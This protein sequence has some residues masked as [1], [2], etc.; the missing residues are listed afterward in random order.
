MN[1]RAHRGHRHHQHVADLAGAL[2]AGEQAQHLGLTLGQA[3]LIRQSRAALIAGALV[4]AARILVGQKA[5][6]RLGVLLRVHVE[7]DEHKQDEHRRTDD[8]E[9]RGIENKVFV[10]LHSHKVAEQKADGSNEK[11]PPKY[12][13][14][15]GVDGPADNRAGHGEQCIEIIKGAGLH[16]ESRQKL[17][18][19]GERT[20]QCRHTDRREHEAVEAVPNER[21]VH[22]S[23]ATERSDEERECDGGAHE[24]RRHPRHNAQRQRQR[25]DMEKA[26]HHTVG[27]DDDE[28]PDAQRHPTAR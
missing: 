14:R 24:K 27:A 19:V 12:L 4:A 20:E 15:R 28:E 6:N 25:N 23:P 8:G 10:H 21:H 7:G 1:V 2:V 22:S 16:D 13:G 18:A 9:G 11:S 5:P 17:T 26:E 3:E